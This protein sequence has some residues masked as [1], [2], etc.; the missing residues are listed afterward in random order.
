MKTIIIIFLIAVLVFVGFNYIDKAEAADMVE[1]VTEY[2]EK[3]V[4]YEVE[5]IVYEV[6]EKPIEVIKEIENVVYKNYPWREFDSV[7]AFKD[8]YHAQDFKPLV[9][10]NDCDDE[11]LRLQR[12]AFA[13]GYYVSVALSRDGTYYGVKVTKPNHAGN[14]VLIDGVFYWV[15][16]T[17][18]EFK[19]I[20]VVSRN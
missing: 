16:P 1:Y 20:K 15:E 8:W 6:V 13:Q 18:K 2:V 4:Y 14:L 10:K 11:A 5:R 9:F 12:I 7:S 17:P 19:V 3:P